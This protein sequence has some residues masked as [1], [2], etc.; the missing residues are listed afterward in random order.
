[1]Q[2]NRQVLPI[3]PMSNRKAFT[4]IELL[5]VIAIIAILAAILFPVFA[6]AREKAR[7]TSCLSNEKQVGLAM[8]QYVQDY[9]ETFPAG[10][11]YEWSP[12]PQIVEPYFK[13]YDM[14][15]CPSDDRNS[16]KNGD[17]WGGLPMSYASNGFLDCSTPVCSLKGALGVSQTWVNKAGQTLAA[18][19]RPTESIL[20]AEKHNTDLAS[21]SPAPNEWGNFNRT[22]VQTGPVIMGGAVSWYDPDLI[23]DGS[24]PGSTTK[25]DPNGPNGAVSARHSYMSNFLFCDGHVKSMKPAATNPQNSTNGDAAQKAEENASKNMWDV[26]RP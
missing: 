3:V 10:M 7:Q 17:P 15:V 18:I 5:V 6:Q 21:V 12:W 13:S 11:T 8:L 26:T 14:L 25:Y 4:L 22:G 19:N 23:P 20:L 2:S 1:M 9:D 16:Q 24:R